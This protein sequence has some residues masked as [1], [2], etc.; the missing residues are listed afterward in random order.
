[1]MMLMSIHT[2]VY[3]SA[4]EQ[5]IDLAVRHYNTICLL[6]AHHSFAHQSL[7]L[8]ASSVVRE[9]RYV[10]C[11]LLK[12]YQFTLAFLTYGDGRIRV[13][14]NDCIATDDVQLLLEVRKRIGYGIEV[15]H[16]KQVTITGLKCR[17]SA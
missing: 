17:T 4:V 14:P 2:I 3:I 5:R 1:M 12:I 11:Q 13:H 16:R 9:P 8:H 6:A 15:R 7:V 10:R